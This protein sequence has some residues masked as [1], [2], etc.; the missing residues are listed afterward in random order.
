MLPI[1]HTFAPLGD[2]RQR[3]KALAVSYAPWRYKRGKSTEKFKEVLSTAFNADAFLFASGRESLLA[4]LRAIG[5]R[6]G[7]EVIIQS[8]TCIVLPNAIHAA[9]GV[10]IYA[11][12]ERETLNLDL[13]S[14]RQAITPRTRAII[15]QHTFGIPADLEALRSLC[16]ERKLILIEDCAHSIPDA[17]T[18][19]AIATRGDYV[20][21]SFG[22]DKAIS[23]VAG[24]AMLSRHAD[25]SQILGAEEAQAIDLSWWTIARLLE[26]PQ[27]YGFCRPL[28]GIGIGKAL[29]WLAGKL[30]LLIPINTPSEKRG[31]ASPLLHRMPNV[32]AALALEQFTRLHEINDHRR[33]LTQFYL[34]EC[35][36]HG[37]PTLKGVTAHLALQKFPM[38]IASKAS[39]DPER[40]RRVVSAQTIRKQ[41]KR[42]NILLEDGWTGCV[43][44]P[45]GVDL[46][47]ASYQWGQDPQAEAV[48]EQILS[49]PTH[50]LMTLN[51]AKFL[52]EKLNIELENR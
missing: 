15:C 7:E 29:L 5:L 43:V 18:P 13:E 16:D 8:Y 44:C 3:R 19:H 38:F 36:K 21:F 25:V 24:G 9:G 50:P 34:E 30:T 49:L 48:C 35:K 39:N 47:A 33:T 32:C 6:A 52:V 37:L 46:D 17:H 28:Y 12:I 26:Y 1:H 2:S 22:R 20:M 14:V 27:I 4:L 51:Q 11:D 42:H 23:G 31:L 10:P 41:L 40:S 45:R